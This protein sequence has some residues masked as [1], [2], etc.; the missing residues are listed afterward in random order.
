MLVFRGMESPLVFILSMCETFRGL[1]V[2]LG[3]NMLDHKFGWPWVQCRG[4]TLG[5]DIWVFSLR[6]LFNSTDEVHKTIV[7]W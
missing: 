7:F 1:G 4:K 6:E 5:L 2:G 3:R